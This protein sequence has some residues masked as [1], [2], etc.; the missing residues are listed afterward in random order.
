MSDEMYKVL[1]IEDDKLDQLAFERL[2]ETEKL[3]YEYNIVSSVEMASDILR[4]QKFDIVIS[5]YLLGDGTAFDLLDLVKNTPVIVVTGI[6]NEEV[7]VNAWRAG[8]Y[9]Y[10]AK[11]KEGSYLKT[12]PI[13]VENAI[14]HKRAEGNLQ[15][16][17]G[18]IMSTVDSVY[19]TNMEDKITFVN[20]AFCNTYGYKKE[21][22]LGKNSS[23]LWLAGHK[24][25]S[26]RTVFKTHGLGDRWE[27]GFYHRRKDGG[28]FPVSISKSII[29]D[30]NGNKIA[31]VGTVRDITER[32]LVEDE[33]RRTNLKLKEQ[34]QLK[35]E[36]AMKVSEALIKM[37]AHES[38]LDNPEQKEDVWKNL[39]K[40]GKLL[41][42]FRDILQIDA[43]RL[44][45]QPVALD[46]G[47]MISEIVDE[48]SNFADKK[49]IELKSFTPDLKLII[50][51]E[52]DRLAQALNSIIEH[53]I[54]VTPSNNHIEIH[55][56]DAGSEVAVE[57]QNGGTLVDSGSVDDLF[58]CYELIKEMPNWNL[59]QE[60]ALD[61]S[62]AKKIVE[63]H[64]GEIWVETADD[65]GG[66]ILCISL[67]KPGIKDEILIS[68]KKV[69][70]CETN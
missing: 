11:D 36:L 24:T 5:D 2:V 56:K 47:E 4:R 38:I 54:S 40:A 33:L 8:A 55:F 30:A 69:Q 62:I 63:L 15:L 49:G 58:N 39:S 44:K 35:S 27:I 3:H 46:I 14:N 60:Q 64:G 22:I 12:L 32:I 17:S 29:K 34:C 52:R 51:G 1:M 68:S 43:G 41:S 65:G 45:L 9:D 37:L 57:V 19:I 23:V 53:V 20:K 18:A 59:G 21:E 70:S 10:L 31:V 61:L 48:L 25:T 42:D 16:L 67:P 7:A 6:G 50:N 26:T 13:T 28:I 66:N